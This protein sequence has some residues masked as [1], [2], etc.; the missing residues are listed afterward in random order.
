M[1]RMLAS[2]VAG[3]LLVVTA[4]SA[5]SGPPRYLPVP[6]DHR[7]VDPSVRFEGVDKYPEYIFHLVVLWRDADKQ[8]LLVEVKEAKILPLQFSGKDV[9]K[10]HTPYASLLLKAMKR[11][12]F[13]KRAKDDPKLSWL[14]RNPEGVLAVRLEPPVLTVPIAQKEV[15]VT[16]YRVKLS[17]G[18]LRA[19]KVGGDKSGTAFPGG[20][21]PQWA[22]GLTSSLS[23]A[24]LGIWL[25]RRG[26]TAAKPRN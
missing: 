17:D 3:I 23:L 26:T 12:D 11:V 8:S 22:F 6:K 9:P 2:A 14:D 25:A 13:A 15:P 16:T 24:W 7:P 5:N 20:L 19:E 18:E 21:L 10:D 4:L 1:T